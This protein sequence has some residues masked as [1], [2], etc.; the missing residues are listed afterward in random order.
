[1]CWRGVGR[2][3]DPPGH[4]GCGSVSLTS[5]REPDVFEGLCTSGGSWAAV[6]LSVRKRGKLAVCCLS[7][8]HEDSLVSS[9]SS[10]NGGRTSGAELHMLY[11]TGW[12][13]QSA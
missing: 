7:V 8:R 5:P 10:G 12:F 11:G 13:A 2:S 9:G 4:L 3:V 1:M 6:R